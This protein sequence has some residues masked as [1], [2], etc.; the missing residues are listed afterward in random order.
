MT[1]SHVTMET[2]ICPICGKEEETGTVLLDTRLRERFEMH[3]PTQWKLCAEHQKLHEDGFIALVEASN[4]PLDV[5]RMQPGDARRTGLICHVKRNIAT[6]LFG[7]GGEVNLPMF[8]V[9]PGVIQSI[10]NRVAN[11][12]EREQN[13]KIIGEAK[14]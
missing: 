6:E 5:T 1:K 9:E 10:N 4:P 11:A 12:V 2:G 7:L 8:F 13:Q 3:T 14:I